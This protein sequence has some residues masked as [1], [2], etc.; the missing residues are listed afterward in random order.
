MKNRIFAALISLLITITPQLAVTAE[1]SDSGEE[2]EESSG[3]VA[4]GAAG[5]AGTT[6][7]TAG[8]WLLK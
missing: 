1:G 4:A 2:E 5:A 7:A 3:A 8:V 6:G